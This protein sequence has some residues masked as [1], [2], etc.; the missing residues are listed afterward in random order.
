MRILLCDIN[1]LSIN[2]AFQGRRF[3]TKFA[4]EYE[5]LL[6]TALPK[7][8]MI[9]GKVEITY[10]FYLKHH[11]LTDYDNC[12]KI[13]QDILVKKGY[14]ED[15]RKIYKATIYKIPAKQDSI[16]IIIKELK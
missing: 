4:K 8:E 13:L 1:P 14:I 12:I 11:A 3:K 9:K 7:E 16:G 5:R 15:D 2:K 10:H 6:F